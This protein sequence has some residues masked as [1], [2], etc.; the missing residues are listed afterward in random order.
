MLI[1]LD[2]DGVLIHA[3]LWKKLEILSDG[4]PKFDNQAAQNL[5]KIINKTEASIVLTT[6]H[7]HK[8]SNAEWEE[9]FKIR[10]I[11]ADIDCLDNN[12]DNLSR[13]DEIM[14]WVDKNSSENYVIIDDDKSLNDLP[15]QIKNKLVL[16]NGMVG[17]DYNA[18]ELAILILSSS[19]SIKF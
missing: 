8:Y 17:I 18:T 12:I 5:Q 7:K 14:K 11:L 13:K 10:E 1:L 15:V 4:F 16:V 9:I 3:K 2:I 19:N 6:S